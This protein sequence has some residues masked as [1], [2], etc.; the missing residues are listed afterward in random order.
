MIEEGYYSA[1]AIQ[2]DDENG[3]P[4]YCRFG[5]A[6]TGTK[7]CLVMFTV[8]YDDGSVVLPWFGFFGSESWERTV[9]SLRY[10]GFRG[11]DI[12]TINS[13]KL[14]EPVTVKVEHEERN[15][16][17]VY[18]R[19]AFVNRPGA[20][21][22]FNSP[23]GANELRHFAAQLKQR[24]SQ[25]APGSATTTRIPPSEQIRQAMNTQ[26]WNPTG[27]PDDDIFF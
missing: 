26:G 27:N 20:R 6:S 15:D 14:D 1:R 11:D 8:E 25:Q 21:I 4:V 13:Q 16:G 18:A 10:C 17:R 7:Q 5:T 19:V 12:S 3:R 23:M 9:Q 2:V 22:K 24:M